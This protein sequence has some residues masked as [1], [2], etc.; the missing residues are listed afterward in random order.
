MSF[1]FPNVCENKSDQFNFIGFEDAEN[2]AISCKL[3]IR[4][5][6]LKI[7]IRILDQNFLKK[8]N[9]ITKD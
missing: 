1:I 2:F 8:T 5:S 7:Q 9:I 4:K 3:R 6:I